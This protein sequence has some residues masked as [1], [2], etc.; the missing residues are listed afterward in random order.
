MMKKFYRKVFVVEFICVGILLDFT[1]SCDIIRYH[2]V[3]C[4]G[5]LKSLK[6]ERN[7]LKSKSFLIN[8][9]VLKTKSST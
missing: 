2:V 3:K 9:D 6:G 8:S 7:V 4:I 1:T 5:A